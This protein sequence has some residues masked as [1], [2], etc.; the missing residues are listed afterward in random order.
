M[1]ELFNDFGS[2]QESTEKNL[3]DLSD[4]LFGNEMMLLL[5]LSIILEFLNSLY[6]LLVLV[7]PRPANCD[8]LMELGQSSA[9]EISSRFPEACLKRRSS[10][11]LKY[12]GVL[13][14]VLSRR[15]LSCA[16]NYFLNFL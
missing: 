16:N 11:D 6:V 8:S 9:S 4:E 3:V 5:Q 1:C 10:H 7:N 15:K 12:F 2:D 14:L 13:L